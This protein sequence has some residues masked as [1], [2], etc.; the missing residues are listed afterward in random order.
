MTYEII[1]KPAALE[2]LKAIK[3][4][5]LQASIAKAVDSLSGE[6]EKKG[7][8]L[9]KDLAGYRSVRVAGQRYR[10]VYRIEADQV[11]VIVVYLGIRKE[12]DK[13]DVY[14]VVK[15]LIKAGL[16]DN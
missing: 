16:L 3:D 12:G 11:V 6:P 8:P 14:T 15:K 2:A 1:L 5:R 13:K 9:Q 7:K 10:V 4:R